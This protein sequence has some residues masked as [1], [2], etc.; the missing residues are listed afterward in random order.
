M[1]SDC[2][3]EPET[4]M[5][6]TGLVG[7]EEVSFNLLCPGLPASTTICHAAISSPQSWISLIH[8]TEMATPA[9]SFY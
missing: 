4:Y 9:Q 6:G 1:G 8:Q 5:K 7:L 3:Q 2:R